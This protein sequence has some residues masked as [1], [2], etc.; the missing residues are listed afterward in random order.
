MT[1]VQLHSNLT[2]ASFTTEQIENPVTGDRMTILCSTHDSNGEYVKF[3]FELPPGSQGSPLHYHDTITETFEVLSGSLEMQFGESG[4]IKVL[5][6]GEILQVPPGLQHSF[7]N[8]S[9]DWVTFISVVR[10]AGDFEHFL[11]SLYGLAINGKVNKEG[12]PTN[13]LQFALLIEKA[14]TIVVGLPVFLQKLM[15]K[16]LATVARLLRV[17]KSLAKYK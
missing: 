14:D 11:R 12:A 5:R 16:V 1:S 6:P 2:H 4:N 15:I 10:P 9:E 17:E 7:R 3:Q 8:A 13:L